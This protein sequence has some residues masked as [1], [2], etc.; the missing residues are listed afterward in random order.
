MIKTPGQNNSNFKR[1]V[2]CD[3]PASE[4]KWLQRVNFFS[5]SND[6]AGDRGTRQMRTIDST[7]TS[8]PDL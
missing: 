3:K 5:R 4:S 1:V 2:N 6:I 8:E 7:Q